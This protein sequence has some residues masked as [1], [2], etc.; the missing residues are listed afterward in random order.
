MC[1]SFE[2]PFY[3]RSDATMDL[4]ILS[5]I[6]KP[7]A[8]IMSLIVGSIA[9]ITVTQCYYNLYFPKRPK[10]EIFALNKLHQSLKNTYKALLP[11]NP[12]TYLGQFANIMSVALFLFVAFL[13]FTFLS[14]N[15]LKIKEKAVM[16]TVPS[17][18]NLLTFLGVTY[19]KTLNFFDLFFGSDKEETVDTSADDL[20]LLLKKASLEKAASDPLEKLLNFEN[21]SHYSGK[22]A[23][24]ASLSSLHVPLT[25][26][27]SIYSSLMS[28]QILPGDSMGMPTTQSFSVAKLS[29]SEGKIVGK[30]LGPATLPSSSSR[31]NSSPSRGVTVLGSN[32]VEASNFLSNINVFMHVCYCLL[33]I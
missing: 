12:K 31:K 2:I 25:S 11:F 5:L 1:S 8:F 15:E 32:K 23:M 27:D 33:I 28:P 19:L 30:S 29:R 6:P 13:S 4:S 20:A 3:T 21:I 18:L 17:V 24:A 14:S 9:S 22:K 26:T 7:I 10:N 16:Y